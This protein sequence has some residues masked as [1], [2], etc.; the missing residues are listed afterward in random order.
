MA[1]DGKT[2]LWDGYCVELIQKLAEM[3]DFDYDIVIPTEGDFGEKKNGV[4]DGLVGDL[5]KGVNI[6][7]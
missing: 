6:Y 2:K 7:T 1:E 3:M 5:S 4:W